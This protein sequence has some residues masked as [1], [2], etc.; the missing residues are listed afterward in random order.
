MPQ[1]N[2]HTPRAIVLVSGGLDSAV[3]LAEARAEGFRTVA[4]SFDYHQRHRV[5]LT[6]AR[7]VAEAGGAARHVIAPLNLRLYAGSALTSDHIDVPKNRLDEQGAADEIPVTYVPARNL[8]FLAHAAALAE[9]EG[10]SAIFIGVNALDYSGYPDCRPAFIEAV[11]QALN[12]G[13]SAGVK[14]LE[15]K[16]TPAIQVRTPLIHL[17]KDQIITRGL[18]LGVD[19][20]MTISCYD[21]DEQGR[22]CAACDACLLRLRGFERADRPDPGRYRSRGKTGGSS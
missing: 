6:A 20:S 11:E 15:E 4:L 17:R 3:A 19:F 18:E 21:P 2:D 16:N 1:P 12:L 9:V 5:E 13:T 22:A 7:R 8:I 14:T 10:A